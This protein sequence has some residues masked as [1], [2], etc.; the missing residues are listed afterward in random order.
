MANKEYWYGWGTQYSIGS[1]SISPQFSIGT[2]VGLYSY[3]KTNKDGD[4]TA[5]KTTLKLSKAYSGTIR[6]I[7]LTEGYSRDFTFNNHTESTAFSALLFDG[8]DNGKQF[9]VR[10]EIIS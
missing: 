9:N 8:S 5:T 1:I 10:F 3:E 6:Y 7:N 2:I 4:T